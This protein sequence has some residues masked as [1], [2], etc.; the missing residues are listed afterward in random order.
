MSSFGSSSEH[1]IES[2]DEKTETRVDD[3][4]TPE[5][6]KKAHEGEQE[7]QIDEPGPSRPK[8]SETVLKNEITK[9]LELLIR[10]CRAAEPSPEMKTIIKS[11]VLKYYHMVHPDFVTSKMFIQTLKST[12]DEIV[13]EPHLVYSKLK[14]I[15][16]ELD[17]RRKSKATVFN[18]AD[19]VDVT[20]GTG[21][22]TKDLH[23][24][25]L[26][27]A[28]VKLKRHILELEEAEVDWDDDDNSAYLKKVRF[29][30]RA[31]EIYE[32]ICEIT[33]E[34][35]HAHRIVKKPIVF[36]SKE[37]PEF[38]KKLQKTV[39]AKNSF[40]NF[41]DV[42]KCLDYC[43]KRYD[44]HLSKDQMKPIAQNAFED[45]GKKLQARRRNDLYE[46]TTFY[47]GK[48]KDPAKDDADLRVMLEKNKKFYGR[49][50]EV[51]NE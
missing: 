50:D 4:M 14:V 39:N 6:S 37:F 25:K 33:G 1:E 8:E 18:N 36:K 23:L 22:E 47:V 46:T 44:L 40:P 29:E 34:S 45:L 19:S 20:G 27:K 17:A 15:I 49:C 51:I 28:L 10:A 9:E 30:K 38:Y 24:R 42:L 26:Y 11:K 13:K 16:E 12:T 7:K 21:D 5:N 31:C 41:L 2:Q 35:T 32:K 3:E 48:E 43:N